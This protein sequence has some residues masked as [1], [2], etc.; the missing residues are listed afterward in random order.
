MPMVDPLVPWLETIGVVAL[1][2]SG[3]WLGHFFARRQRPYWLIGYIIPFILLVSIGLSRRYPALEFIPPFSWL[4]SGRT[5]FAATAII[6]TMLLVTPLGRVQNKRLAILVYSFLVCIITYYAIFPF[7]LPAIIRKDL[8]RMQTRLDNH[9]V[10]LQSTSYN[11]GPA[12]AVTVLRNIGMPAEEGKI[13]VMSHTSPISG[14]PPDSLYLGLNKM[15]A[16][17]GLHFEYRRFDTVAELVGREPMIAIVRFS[18]MVDHY[19]AVLKV[20]QNKLTVGDPIGG[21]RHMTYNQFRKIWRNSA[22][23]LSP[24]PLKTK[25]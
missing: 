8:L 18:F 16:G 2:L 12:A 21:I 13:A 14:T 5:E 6:T 9:N 20:N 10:C 4:M 23:I 22:I 3:V 19:V 17:S 7:L 15:Y 11:C 24:K 25:I 1:G